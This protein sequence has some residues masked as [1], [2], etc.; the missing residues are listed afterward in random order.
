M[1]SNILLIAFS[2]LLG[3]YACQPGQDSANQPVKPKT[4][5]NDYVI[6]PGQRVGPLKAVAATE[7]D[8]VL[9]FGAQKVVAM[10]VYIGEGMEM[11]GYKVYPDTPNELEV[12]YDPDQA[13]DKPAFLRVG[14]P[15]SKWKT[16]TGVKIGISLQK[17][18]ALN[19]KPFMFSGFGWDYG[20]RVTNWNGGNFDANLMITLENLSENAPEALFGEQEI[21]SDNPMLRNLKIKVSVME[22]RL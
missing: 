4:P 21:S 12:V 19:G 1:R 2:L 14:H 17:L 10:P 3:V 5:K 22:V 8:L 20:G 9:A 7:N 11:P 16:N 15:R 6:I 13:A 18:E